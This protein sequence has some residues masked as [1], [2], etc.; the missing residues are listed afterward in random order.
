MAVAVAL[1]VQHGKV[2]KIYPDITDKI[3]ITQN[4]HEGK[5]SSAFTVSLFF[6]FFFFQNVAIPTV[7]III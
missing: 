6:V 7:W 1:M 5:C 3:N 2:E 4:W